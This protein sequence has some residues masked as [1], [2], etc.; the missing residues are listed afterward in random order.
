[1]QPNDIIDLQTAAFFVLSRM[2]E[3]D[4]NYIKSKSIDDL[5]EVMLHYHHGFGTN[6]RNT[7]KLWD[8][9]SPVVKWFGAKYDL[10]HA[11]DISSIIMLKTFRIILSQVEHSTWLETNDDWITAK[12]SEYHKHWKKL[13]LPQNGIPP[14]N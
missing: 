5:E 7:L 13:G 4:I 2:S 8:L 3:E 12:A 10:Q 6:V 14:S 9:N 1:M 11:D